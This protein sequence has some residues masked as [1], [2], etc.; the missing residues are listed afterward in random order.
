MLSDAQIERYSRQ[1]IL[2][3]IGARGQERL[4]STSVAVLTTEPADSFLVRYLVAAGIG[5]MAAWTCAAESSTDADWID[6]ASRLN[7]DCRI[8]IPTTDSAAQWISDKR[9]A[10][11][12]V[13]NAPGPETAAVSSAC[14]GTGAPLVWGRVMGA[15][16]ML[17]VFDPTATPGCYACVETQTGSASTESPELQ[18]FAASILASLQAAEAIKIGLGQRSALS[19]RR[20]LID[21]AT[22]LVTPLPI[23]HDGPC[24]AC[25][26][27]A[28]P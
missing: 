10:V 22:A 7:P 15:T 18:S 4:L 21:T 3:E 5:R 26:T 14:I 23:E 2:P 25:R 17:A 11:A 1:I 8:E 24:A 6:D 12:I 27:G 28:R 20:L 16:A 19:G 13:N 9:P